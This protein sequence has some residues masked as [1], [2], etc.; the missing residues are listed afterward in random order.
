MGK[1]LVWE[2]GCIV[3]LGILAGCIQA[4]ALELGLLGRHSDL[5]VIPELLIG[6]AA[7]AT[8]YWLGWWGIAVAVVASVTLYL[9][10]RRSV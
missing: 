6:G 3:L 8:A 9:R 7:G 2:I 10:R 5:P 4:R 1:L